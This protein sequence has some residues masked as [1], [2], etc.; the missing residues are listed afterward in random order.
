MRWG[1]E[2]TQWNARL[3]CTGLEA[4]S[5]VYVDYYRNASIGDREPGKLPR[6]S[7]S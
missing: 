5:P 1:T 2:R 3:W 6:E 7:S 4:E